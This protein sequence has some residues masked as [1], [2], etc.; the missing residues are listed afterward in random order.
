M[1]NQPL[2]EVPMGFPCKGEGI[3]K[4]ANAHAKIRAQPRA[5]MDSL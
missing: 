2:Y 1:E 5:T 4:L 3:N